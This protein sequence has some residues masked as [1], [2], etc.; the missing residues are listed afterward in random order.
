MA[1]SRVQSRRR[2]VP[3]VQRPAC[4]TKTGSH[5]NSQPGRCNCNKIDFVGSCGGVDAVVD[6]Q[7]ALYI[8]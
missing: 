7:W 4:K 1:H 8:V 5:L 6:H 3:T 2:V